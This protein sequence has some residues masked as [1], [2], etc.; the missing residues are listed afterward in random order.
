MFNMRH[1]FYQMGMDAF[2]PLIV[3]FINSMDDYVCV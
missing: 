3:L 1:N 2:C